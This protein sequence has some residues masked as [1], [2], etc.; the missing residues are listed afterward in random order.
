VFLFYGE[1]EKSTQAKATIRTVA[2]S[3]ASDS[4]FFS[5]SQVEAGMG[6][7]L[8]EYLGVSSSDLPVVYLAHPYEED[9]KKYKLTGDLTVDSLKQFVDDFKNNKLVPVL[10]SEEIPTTQEGNVVTVVGKNFKQIVFDETKDV[11]VEFYAPWCGHCKNLVPIYEELATKF[12]EDTNLVI[13][14]ID[15]T[16]N[17][18]EGANV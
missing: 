15:A 5:T 12:K 3:L 7:R 10:K 11:L 13:A 8:G 14:K 1:D 4:L 9:V 18:V 16:A 6:Q 2:E 17:E